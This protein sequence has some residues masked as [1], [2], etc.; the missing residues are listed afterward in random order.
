[1]LP[2]L[3]LSTDYYHLYVKYIDLSVHDEE[4]IFI[5]LN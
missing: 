2:A 4:E 1:M 3:P 5:K